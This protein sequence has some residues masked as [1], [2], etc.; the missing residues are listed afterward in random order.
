[1]TIYGIIYRTIMKIAHHYNWH[2]A[3]PIGPLQPGNDMQLWCQ[4]CGLRETYNKRQWE[5]H[6]VNKDRKK[7]TT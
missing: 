5:I 3:P 7:D 1:M 2:Y 4:W 6:P